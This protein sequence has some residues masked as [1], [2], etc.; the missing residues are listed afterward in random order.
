MA[1][2][3]PGSYDLSRSR[4]AVEAYME[5]TSGLNNLLSPQAQYANALKNNQKMTNQ[6]VPDIG[7]EAPRPKVKGPSIF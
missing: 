4:A 6:A 7:Y 2:Y 1:G 3:F 5:L